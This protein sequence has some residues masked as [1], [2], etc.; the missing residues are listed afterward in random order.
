MAASLSKST[1]AG[2]RTPSSDAIALLI[3]DHRSVKALFQQFEELA[4]QEDV[5]DRKALLVDRICT[6]LT[7]HAQVED[8]LFYPAV[9]AAIGDDALMDEADIEHA[10]AEDLI[11]Q[12]EDMEPGDDHFDARVTV[13]GEYVDHHVREEEEEMFVKA[14]AADA[15]TAALAAEMARRKDELMAEF[16]LDAEDERRAAPVPPE[17]QA[18]APTMRN[19][20]R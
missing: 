12:L 16:G 4:G 6:E 20:R 19:E 9:R 17:P 14:R 15:I 13:L 2:V 18:P 1:H 3:A 11:A 8:E 10:S 7:V 5:G